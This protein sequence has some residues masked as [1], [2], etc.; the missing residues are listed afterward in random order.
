MRSRSLVFWFA[1]G[2]GG[3]PSSKPPEPPAVDAEDETP[4]DSDPAQS[5]APAPTWSA[6]EVQA[7]AQAALDRGIPEPGSIRD[8]YLHMFDTWA[9]ADC[10]TGSGYNLPGDYEGCETESG[11]WFYGH[12]EYDA[13]G[14][15]RGVRV[16]VDPDGARFEAAGELELT[17]EEVSGTRAIQGMV[18]GSWGYPPGSGFLSEVTRSALFLQ[19]E[20][21]GDDRRLT[22]DGSWGNSAADIMFRGFELAQRTCPDLLRGEMLVR[23]PNGYWHSILFDGNCGGCGTVQGSDDAEPVIVC[24]DIAEAGEVVVDGLERGL[25]VDP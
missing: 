23:E 16:S 24:L 7:T 18:L 21:N 11:A 6:V 25:V 22:L 12:G 19:Y 14:S 9:D 17:G 15:P 20:T 2:C 13:G 5:H 1:A 8:G 4:T 3:Q 10:P